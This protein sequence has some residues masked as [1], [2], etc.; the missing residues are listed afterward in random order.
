[1]KFAYKYANCGSDACK[2]HQFSLSNLTLLTINIRLNMA[3]YLLWN[4]NN[5]KKSMV[6]K[7]NPV[8]KAKTQ[9]AIL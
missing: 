2:Q 8:M 7:E 3:N 9:N 5:V 6:Y 4:F 1:M